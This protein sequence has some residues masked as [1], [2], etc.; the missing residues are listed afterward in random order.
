MA[1]LLL[2]SAGGSP[3][4]T[5]LAVGLSLTWPRPV[6][7]VDADPGAHQAV[8]AGYLAGRSA[9]GRGLLRVAEAHR[10]HRPL[11]EVVIDQTIALSEEGQIQRRFLPG[12]TKPGSAAHFASVWEE[13]AETF[14]G[15][16]EVDIDVIIDCGRLSTAGLPGPLVERSAVTALM[17]QSNLRA[18]MSARTYLP[19]LRDHARLGPDDHGRLGLVIRG[20]GQPYGRG[21]ISK[22]LGVPVLADVVSDPQHA[23]CLS[24]GRPPTR[25]FEVSSLMR[26][27]RDASTQFANIM[28]RSTELARSGS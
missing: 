7:L 21:E 16:A 27:V 23:G 12:F 17:L 2:T 28:Q 15:L 25:R 26:S 1:I 22:S 8:L 3:G 6:L 24:D 20:Q 14:D 19:T 9:G 11:R 18:I 10:D 13:L 4:V 5:T